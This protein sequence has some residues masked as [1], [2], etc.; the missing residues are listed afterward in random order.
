MSKSAF[1]VDDTLDKLIKRYGIDSAGARTHL[2]NSSRPWRHSAPS[3]SSHRC[4]QAR[5]AGILLRR[6]VSTGAA[7]AKNACGTVETPFTDDVNAREAAAPSLHF[8]IYAGEQCPTRC[9]SYDVS[10]QPRSA[11]F[12]SLGLGQQRAN[13][14]RVRRR[15]R[16]LS[17]KCRIKGKSCPEIRVHV[18]LTTRRLHE[19]HRLDPGATSPPKLGNVCGA[20]SGSAESH[21]GS[22]MVGLI[23]SIWARAS[24]SWIASLSQSLDSSRNVAFN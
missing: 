4:V 3:D 9:N 16:E 18:G 13:V 24:S 15:F 21:P 11:L 22:N 19:F 2:S 20:V 10:L 8:A 6:S 1:D 7:S 12:P 14:F 5:T 23:S 17:A